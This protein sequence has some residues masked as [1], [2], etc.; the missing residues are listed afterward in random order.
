MLAVEKHQLHWERLVNTR[1]WK[2][3]TVQ[4][5][6]HQVNCRGEYTPTLGTNTACP[7]YPQTNQPDNTA[8]TGT[9]HV[10]ACSNFSY[11]FCLLYKHEPVIQPNS[12]L[13]HWFICIETFKSIIL[14]HLYLN[15]IQGFLESMKTKAI[16][17]QLRILYAY[18]GN[19]EG[20]M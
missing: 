12:W 5:Q 1:G 9:L 16:T 17:K 11:T 19:Y 18:C 7:N 6:P 20:E 8:Q 4:K 15:Q 2:P 14:S 3:K 10:L 13:P